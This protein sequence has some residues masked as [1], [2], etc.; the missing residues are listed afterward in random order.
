MYLRDYTPTGGKRAL[1]LPCSV[2]AR[3]NCFLAFFI[4]IIAWDFFSFVGWK[5]SYSRQ[6]LKITPNFL[7]WNFTNNVTKTRIAVYKDMPNVKCCFMKAMHI[8]HPSKKLEYKKKKK[9][10]SASRR[11]RQFNF[12]WKFERALII[13]AKKLVTYTPLEWLARWNATLKC[14]KMST[15]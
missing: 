12:K 6:F 11:L 14:K 5:C 13:P 10:N 15:W 9:G 4:C 1:Q 7:S 8:Y 3:R 2:V